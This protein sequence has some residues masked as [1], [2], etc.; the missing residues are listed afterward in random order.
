MN[1]SLES[2]DIFA[3]IVFDKDFYQH[4]KIKPVLT[5]VLNKIQTLHND[6][7][8]MEFIRRE[9]GV[10]IAAGLKEF[11]NTHLI[12]DS[13][14]DEQDCCGSGWSQSGHHRFVHLDISRNSLSEM[15]REKLLIIIGHELGHPSEE[16]VTH[17]AA[18][19][20]LSDVAPPFVACDY[21]V[22]TAEYFSGNKNKTI[23]DHWQSEYHA[24]VFLAAIDTDG[25]GIG[26]ALTEYGSINQKF[27]RGEIGLTTARFLGNMCSIRNRIVMAFQ[28]N[29]ERANRYKNPQEE[30]YGWS[31]DPFHPPPISRSAK[32]AALRRKI[33]RFEQKRL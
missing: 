25:F 22:R 5:T 10:D 16:L 26:T 23:A 21:D 27:M 8:K 3:S 19:D 4:Y 31:M 13:S 7:E 14:Y 6:P 30:K 11:R 28:E 24:D 32:D 29:P 20:K 15:T 18:L 17:K 9:T 1:Q 2:Q 33:K 12:I